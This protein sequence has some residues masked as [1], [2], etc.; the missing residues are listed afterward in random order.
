MLQ[1]CLIHVLQ[2]IH[3]LELCLFMLQYCLIHMLEHC[4]IHML[5]LCLI[6]MLEHCLILT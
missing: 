2:F 6:H 1:H 3:M 5:E 4:L